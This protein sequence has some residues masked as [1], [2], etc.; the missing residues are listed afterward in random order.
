[1]CKKFRVKFD[2]ICL[3]GLKKTPDAPIR[4]RFLFAIM[5][6]LQKPRDLCVLVQLVDSLVTISPVLEMYRIVGLSWFRYRSK[7]MLLFF[8]LKILFKI[9][10]I[11]QILQEDTI[12]KNKGTRKLIC[13]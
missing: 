1:M 8:I 13:F 7:K 4:R 2:P 3:I 5:G 11:E 10:V 12:E 6:I 9:Y